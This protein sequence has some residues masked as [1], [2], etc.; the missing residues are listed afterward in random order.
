MNSQPP[1][2]TVQSVN[3]ALE[4]LDIVA[5]AGAAIGITEI[6]E[7]SKL[8]QPT[9]HRLLQTMISAGYIY[10]T[11]RRRYALG[12]RLISLSRYAGGALGV[13][14]RPLLTTAVEQ[15]G[16]SASVAML[17]QD[18]ARY[19]AHVPSEHSMR[20]FTEVGNVVPLHSTGVGK[21]ILSTMSDDE[22]RTT[23]GRSGMR[24]RT[25]YTL[26]DIEELLDDLRLTRER[27][28][29]IDNHE[30]EMGVRCV[31]LSIP[32]DLCLAVS[33]SGPGDRFTDDVIENKALPALQNLSPELAAV[34][35]GT[36]AGAV[37]RS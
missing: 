27:G 21:A 36:A 34:I 37:P 30:M 2:G 8:P 19:I 20:M 4:I 10:Q 12:A 32:G 22:V 24:P 9:I 26:T 18:F 23:I 13:S 28:Y 7:Q 5:H 15:V 17:D 29:A 16:E 14:L 11:P 33:L 31:A 25:E 6:A 3:R 1:R 35:G